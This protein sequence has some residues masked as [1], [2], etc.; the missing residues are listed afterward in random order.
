MRKIMVLQHV[1]HEPLGTLNPML[2]DAGFRIRYVNF[3]R[4]PHSEPHLES[5]SGLIIL[6]GP[7]GVYEADRHPHLKV[8][9]RMIEQALKMDIPI[10]GICLGSQLI[11]SVLG[12]HVRK[13]PRWELGWC[14][15]QLTAEGRG[16]SL[17]KDYAPTEKLF[18]LHQD[19]F[20][21]PKSAVHL[22]KSSVC[23]GQAFRMGEKVYGMQFHLE[24]DHAMIT[25]WLAR[26]DNRKII[27]TESTR[28]VESMERDTAQ[29]I[30]R[31]LELSQRT[32]SK[33]I[34]I[35]QL[36]ERP[37]LLGSTHGSLKD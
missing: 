19:T 31:N 27:Q 22:A 33:F 20:D 26:T 36:P 23:D 17:F 21:V 30:S 14:D 7:M 10:L 35:F 25:R 11:A 13:A 3:G 34:E 28:D 5:Y 4:H 24:V 6:G 9:M 15:V 29:L 32:F 1:G 18:Q 8:E 12:A 16:D 2:K 37:V